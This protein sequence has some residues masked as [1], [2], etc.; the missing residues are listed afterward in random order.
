MSHRSIRHR[1]IFTAIALALLIAAGL[2]RTASAKVT[3]DDG[4]II[5]DLGF[6]P[7]THGFGFENYTGDIKPTNLTAVEMRR[8]F[9][10][11]V[12]ARISGDTCDLIPPAQEFMRTTNVDMNGGH[13][14][15]MA[16][17]SML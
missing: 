10:D 3:Q 1:S 14:E 4:K 8:M 13:C 6:R 17:P 5:A 16:V 12:C 7:A 9:G 2:P 11:Q 15:G